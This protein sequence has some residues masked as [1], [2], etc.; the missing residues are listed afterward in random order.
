MQLNQRKEAH[1]WY[2]IGADLPAPTPKDQLL[3]A[4][5]VKKANSIA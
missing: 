1:R 4:E 2:Q 5:A 3:H